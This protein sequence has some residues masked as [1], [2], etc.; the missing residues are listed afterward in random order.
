MIDFPDK[1]PMANKIMNVHC[2]MFDLRCIKY[3]DFWLKISLQNMNIKMC[4][5]LFY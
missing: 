5:Y 2:H 1:N 4:I 3:K